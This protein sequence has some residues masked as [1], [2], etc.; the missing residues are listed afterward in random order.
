MPKCSRYS[1]W[2]NNLNAGVLHS[3]M[4]QSTTFFEHHK[5]GFTRN[6]RV[7]L[8]I[9]PTKYSLLGSKWWLLDLCSSSDFSWVISRIDYWILYFQNSSKF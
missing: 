7:D 9:L 6:K 2:E 4:P 1:N 8:Y 3:C 5:A